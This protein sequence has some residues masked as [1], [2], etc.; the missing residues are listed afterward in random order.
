MDP[1]RK[2]KTRLVVALA[3][4]VLLAAALVYTSFNTSSEAVDPGRLMAS[5]VVGRSYE[6]TG[7]VA[8]DSVSRAGRTMEF[9]VRDRKGA[10]SVPVRYTGAVPDPFREGREVIITVR[11]E[12][13]V[14]VGE[15]DS[16]VTKCPSKYETAS[17]TP[18]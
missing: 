9:R 2:R 11:K 17:E 6:L 3:A 13:A 16:L 8:D 1:S 4:A 5:A 10:A 7:K 15:K 12:G 18:S 14:F